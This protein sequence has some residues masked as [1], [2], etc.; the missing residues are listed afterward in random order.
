M[1]RVCLEKE[2]EGEKKKTWMTLV[3]GLG[4]GGTRPVSPELHGCEE[5]GL[6]GLL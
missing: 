4:D 1:C 5:L 6:Q 2:K 3:P